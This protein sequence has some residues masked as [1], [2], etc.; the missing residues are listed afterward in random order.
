MFL[1]RPYTTMRSRVCACTDKLN[2]LT[3]NVNQ[4]TILRNGKCIIQGSYYSHHIL[5]M[6]RERI[7]DQSGSWNPHRIFIPKIL[8]AQTIYCNCIVMFRDRRSKPKIAQYPGKYRYY[9][10]EIYIN[11]LYE[12]ELG[13]NMEGSYNPAPNR[14]PY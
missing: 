14:H 9:R 5:I 12:S 7:D 3:G 4:K 1:R 2:C 11:S 6:K 13:I 10:N 8:A